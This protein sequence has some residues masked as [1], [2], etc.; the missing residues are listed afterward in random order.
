MRKWKRVETADG[1][2]FRSALASHEAAL[3]KNLATAMIG[4]LDER[5]SS[6]PADEL[7]EI[8]GIKTG[9][10]EPPK[11][12]TLRRLLPDF[13]R[14]DDQDTAPADSADSLNAA[15]RS[16]HEPGIVD[17]KRIAAQRLLSTV[18]EDGG[19]FELSEEDAN[20][21]IGA[22]NDIRLTL[23]V[24][25]EVGPEGP[26]RLPADH[27]LAVHFDVYQWLTVL[28]EYLV[29]VLMGSR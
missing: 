15:L 13:Y 2:R 18:P 5:E 8:T 22:V 17:A 29:L 6:S 9:N 26:E 16:L 25:L 27:P 19:R 4:L 11:D 12:P 1:P 7:E 24:M 23:G 10:A 21:W 28:Q 3:L 20:C 14:N